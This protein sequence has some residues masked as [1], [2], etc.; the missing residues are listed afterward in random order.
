VYVY[1][2]VAIVCLKKINTSPL[3]KCMQ[4]NPCSV[5][6]YDLSVSVAFVT[7]VGIISKTKKFLFQE[8]CKQI[9]MSV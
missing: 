7:K 2:A 8:Y 4:L 1:D 3:Q 5:N 9:E 6:M